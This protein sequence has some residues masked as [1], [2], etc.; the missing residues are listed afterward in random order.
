M[1]H[2]EVPG[3]QH[4]PVSDGVIGKPE[5]H[6]VGQPASTDTFGRR[7]GLSLSVSTGC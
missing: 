4:G 7:R 1:L 3:N 2:I 5:R 6:V